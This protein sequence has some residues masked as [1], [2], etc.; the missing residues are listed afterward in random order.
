[1]FDFFKPKVKAYEDLSSAKF[2]E[3]SKQPDSVLIDVRSA[4]EFA[5]R[6]IPGALNLDV[7]LPDFKNQVR[8]LP[9]NK[10]YLLYCQGGNRSKQAC[11]IMAEYGFETVKNLSGGITRWPFE[12]V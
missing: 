10:T 5:S 12:K 6:K 11:A 9:K 3:F 1:M 4:G 8:N 7:R 2:L